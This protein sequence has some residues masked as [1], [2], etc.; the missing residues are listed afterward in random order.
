MDYHYFT[1][2]PSLYDF[3]RKGIFKNIYLD[4][5]EYPEKLSDEAWYWMCIYPKFKNDIQCHKNFLNYVLSLFGL[6]VLNHSC[7]SSCTK[8]FHLRFLEQVSK[9]QKTYANVFIF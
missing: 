7:S 9:K 4:F 3:H 5:S 2:L 1:Y 6:V 8:K